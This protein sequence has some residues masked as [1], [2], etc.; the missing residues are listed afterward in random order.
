MG[1]ANDRRYYFER[2]TFRRRG[3]GSRAHIEHIH[4]HRP[5]FRLDPLPLQYL[6]QVQQ[7]EDIHY[8][9]NTLNCR[10][11]QNKETNKTNKAR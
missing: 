11:K 7:T 6:L 9:T 3:R 1:W 5:L 2:A 10:Q 4:R 8:N